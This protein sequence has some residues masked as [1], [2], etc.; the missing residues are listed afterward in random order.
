LD[1]V[2]KARRRA[3]RPSHNKTGLSYE[4]LVRGIFQAINDQE[5]VSNLTVE[6]NKT[7]QGKT[8][9]HQIDVYW[10]FQ[11]AGITR[12]VIGG[13]P[14]QA[15]FWLEWGSSIT[16]GSLPASRS[17]SL[18]VHSHSINTRPSRPVAH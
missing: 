12:E 5:Q 16:E 17:R 4:L 8:I 3:G 2:I 6:H 11:R 13:W 14:T 1:K 15:L 9:T 7:L 18:A 10:K